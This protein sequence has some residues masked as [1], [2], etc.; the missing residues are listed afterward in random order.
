[1]KTFLKAFAVGSGLLL[2]SM[3]FAADIDVNADANDL[4]IKGY[5]PVAYFT[6]S[7]PVRGDVNY[8][9]TYKGAIYQFVNENNRDAFRN[10]PEKYAP[11]FGGHCAFGVSMGKKF[12]TDPMAWRIIEDKLY[13]N[14]NAQ[15]QQR[16]LKNTDALIEQADTNWEDIAL[17]AQDDL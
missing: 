15:V 14:L 2:S 5:D 1:M 9:A 12:D 7:Q 17:V 3:A 10:N 16:W 13:L 6:M 8:T 4:A 11:Q